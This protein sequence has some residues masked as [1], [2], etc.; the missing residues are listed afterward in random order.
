MPRLS[1]R[2]VSITLAALSAI[3]ICLFVMFVIDVRASGIQ[4]AICTS[5]LGCRT[6]IVAMVVS[7]FFAFLSLLFLVASLSKRKRG[8]R[9]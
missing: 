7:G 2:G 8:L 9:S 5:G 4:I 1:D 6:N 3:L